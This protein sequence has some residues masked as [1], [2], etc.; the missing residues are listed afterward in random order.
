MNIRPSLQLGRITQCWAM[1]MSNKQN[2]HNAM[3]LSNF[4]MIKVIKVEIPVQLCCEQGIA[5]GRR[6]EEWQNS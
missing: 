5:F 3:E 6:Q 1:A 2:R 4:M